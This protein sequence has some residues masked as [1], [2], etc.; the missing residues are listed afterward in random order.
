M[1]NL[2]ERILDHWETINRLAVRR[3]GARPLAEEA[4]LFAMNGLLENDGRR[5]K[6]FDTK[7]SFEAYLATLTWN[8]L[9]DFSRIRFGRKR[10]PAWL[11]NI[12]GVWLRL[13]TLLCL[14]RL[15]IAEA[16]ASTIQQSEQGEQEKDVEDA[17]WTIR[18][19]VVDCGAHQ[20]LEV[21]LDDTLADGEAKSAAVQVALAEEAEKQELFAILFG[22]LTDTPL[23]VDNPNIKRLCNLKIVLST[24]EKLLLKLCFQDGLTV[25]TAGRML[26]YNRHQAHGRMRRLLSRLRDDFE[27]AGLDREILELLR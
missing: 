2:K 17:A 5:L 24:E 18:Q 12:G 25:T 22:V 13:F 1:S 15:D 21:G 7:S 27:R 14:E 11:R 4:A 3:F 26:G 6:N 8:L 19:E 23:E 10:P 16:V 20:G 9:E